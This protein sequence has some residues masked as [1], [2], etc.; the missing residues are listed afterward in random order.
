MRPTEEAHLRLCCCTCQDGWERGILTGIVRRKYPMVTKNFTPF[1]LLTTAS[2]LASTLLAALII[3]GCA[4]TP[5]R[6]TGDSISIVHLT[7]VHMRPEFN[8]PE[9]FGLALADVRKQQPALVINTGD[10]VDGSAQAE[11]KWGFWKAGIDAELKGV[12]L[13]N[14]LGNHDIDAPLTR[15]KS[16]AILNMPSRYYRFD[17]SGWRFIMLDGNGFAKDQEQWDWLVRELTNTPPK[18]PVAICSHQPIF[19]MGAMIHSP[20]DHIG[21]WRELIALFAKCPNVKLC[22]SGHTHLADVCRYNGVTYACGG[23]LG[24][25]WW[26]VVKSTD[27]KGGYHETPPGYD[28]IKLSPTGVVSVEYRRYPEM[29]STSAGGDVCSTLR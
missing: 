22:L 4:T 18:T 2:K 24:G 16:C 20:G 25:Y 11:I 21:R 1:F 6:N 8:A 12:P 7:D 5:A 10:T 13:Y 28:L 23:S 17:H 14:L 15:G 19:S 29:C 27:G 9:R 3:A 26:E